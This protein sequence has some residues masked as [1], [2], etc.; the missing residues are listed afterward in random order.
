MSDFQFV[1]QELKEMG[2]AKFK[3]GLDRFG[4]NSENS[5]GIR[6][7]DLR[8][9]AKTIGK[10]HALAL[11]LWE[12]GQHETMIL[13]TLVAEKK[14]VTME[15]MESWIKDFNSWDVCDQ[16]IGNLFDKTPWAF[17]KAIEWSGRE[18]EFEKRAGFTMMATLAVHDKK[19][20]DTSFIQFFPY[21]VKECTDNRNFVKKAVNWAIRQI[22][23]RNTELNQEA[24]V[25]S[26]EIQ[27]IESK[28][29]KWIA[30]DAIKELES[31]KVQDR[32]LK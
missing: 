16:C 22:G 1:I 4:I 14:E 15:Q 7:P 9:F 32:F 19:G 11:E 23:K 30:A 31:K 6:M 24:I 5:Y 28:A 20:T 17:E 3:D 2:S 25:L 26:K 10:N 27:A 18:A 12:S 8:A 21:I 13:A 29:A